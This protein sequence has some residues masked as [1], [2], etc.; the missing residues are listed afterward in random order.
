MG[1]EGKRERK[2]SAKMQR[3]WQCGGMF[4]AKRWGRKWCGVSCK[5]KAYRE[6]RAEEARRDATPW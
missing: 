2:K 6:R 1:D 5:L 3:C 4:S